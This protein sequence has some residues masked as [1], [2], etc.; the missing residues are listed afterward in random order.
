MVVKEA[1]NLKTP[2]THSNVLNSMLLRY[3]DIPESDVTPGHA[4]PE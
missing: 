4:A 2:A 3:R 1:V